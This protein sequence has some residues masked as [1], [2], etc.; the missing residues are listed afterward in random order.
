MSHE[1]AVL[2][3]FAALYAAATEARDAQAIVEL[4]DDDEGITFWGSDEPEQ[5]LGGREVRALAEA[6]VASPVSFHFDWRETRAQVAGDVAW[7]N[8]AGT[9]TLAGAADRTVPYR[10]TAVFVRRDGRWLWHTHNGSE[11]NQP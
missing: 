7:V 10:V 9:L 5:A 8:A 4:F 6:I 3:A 11:P 2:A 1:R